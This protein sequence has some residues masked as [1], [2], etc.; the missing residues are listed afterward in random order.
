MVEIARTYRY[1]VRDRDRH[2]NWRYY[3]R[4]PG[5]KKVRLRAAPGT[6]EF[7]DEYKAALLSG[8]VQAG[9]GEIAPKTY[10]WIVRR[11][12]AS[13]D[14]KRLDPETQRL[15]QLILDHTVNEPSS[16]GSPVLFGECPLDRMSPKLVRVLRDRKAAFPHAANNRLKIVRRMFTWAVDNDLMESNPAKEVSQ[17]KAPSE[18][19]HVWSDAE[20][21]LFE[22]RW[23]VGTKERLAFALLRYLGVR[24]SDLVRLGR[25]HVRDGVLTF[26]AAKG[27]RRS[28]VKLELPIPAQL[29]AIIEQSDVGDM[30]Y[31]MTEQGRAF[32]VKGIGAW[33]R[34]RCH[35]AG[36]AD[37]S[38]HGLRK[39]AAV[40]LADAGATAHQ[41]MS[42][43]G[44]RSIKEAERYTRAANQK[45]L[46]ASVVSLIEKGT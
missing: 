31:L 44:W 33:F 23:P 2:G 42:W 39:A 15:Q 29:R 14:F 19:H 1:V 35:E 37:R 36:V 3:I 22:Q 8:A 40:A 30:T 38:A 16:P 5:K 13:A 24:R 17:F 10:G 18:G 26:T 21:A 45:K 20:I 34:S 32:S 11:F 43:F 4:R 25:Q 6:P 28:P 41:L 9:I 12:C 27:K 7:D 46:A